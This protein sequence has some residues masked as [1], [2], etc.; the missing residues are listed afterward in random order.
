MLRA[1]FLSLGFVA[2]ALTATVGTAAAGNTN[3]TGD[4]WTGAQGAWTCWDLTIPSGVVEI[5]MNTSG[6]TGDTDL[7]LF[8]GWGQSWASA[9]PFCSK[10]STT[11]TEDCS[12]ET[13]SRY[14]AG[15]RQFT[16]CVMAYAA[17]NTV[18]VTGGYRTSTGTANSG[19]NASATNYY[20][21]YYR[22][23]LFWP[24]Y[25][26][27]FCLIDFNGS[28]G[29]VRSDQDYDGFSDLD[30]CRNGE[31]YST[32]PNS[33]EASYQSMT[34]VS[35]S[36]TTA[37]N[38]A[39]NCG[40]W[41]NRMHGHTTLND[42]QYLRRPPAVSYNLFTDNNSDCWAKDFGQCMG[43][44]IPIVAPSCVDEAHPAY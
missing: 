29:T 12:V 2:L 3:F 22:D 39:D 17:S 9:S 44:D 30:Y 20:I 32:G 8:N 7:K 21:A 37:K 14:N 35:T 11:T 4:D 15:Q 6:G 43:M 40:R 27:E 36:F 31:H 10:A 33:H 23:L 5:E 38:K 26:R 42:T 24:A 13:Q 1:P 19:A 25:H 28:T 41:T 18:G 34:F 16:I